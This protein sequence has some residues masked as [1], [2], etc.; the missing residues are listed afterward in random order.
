MSP[1]AI[2]FIAMLKSFAKH[3]KS[4]NQPMRKTSN[5]IGTLGENFVA[6]WLQQQGWEILAQRWKCQWGELDIVAY[7]QP[8][9]QLIFVEVKTRSRHSWDTGGLFAITPQKQA[10]VGQAASLFMADHPNLATVACRFDVALVS[11]QQMPDQQLR[12]QNE[13]QFNSPVKRGE[14]VLIKNFKLTLVEYIE[15]AFC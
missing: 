1:Q 15:S 9:A 12:H 5:H 8:T 3:Q 7:S 10:K 2:A 11:C 13:T 4:S 14:P 6:Q